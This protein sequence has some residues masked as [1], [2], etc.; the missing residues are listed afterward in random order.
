[1]VIIFNNYM[2][3]NARVKRRSAALSDSLLLPASTPGAPLRAG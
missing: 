3:K 1:M 2:I